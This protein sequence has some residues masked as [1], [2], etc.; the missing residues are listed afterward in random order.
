MDYNTQATFTNNIGNTVS[1]G[2]KTYYDRNLI[3]SAHARLVHAELGQK[4]PIPLGSGKTIEFRRFSPLP[5]AL[6]PLTEGATPRGN[7][8]NIS[9]V[10]AKVEQY[11]DYVTMS[12]LLITTDLDDMILQTESVLGDQAGRTLDTVIREKVNAG[13]N[14]HYGSGHPE[15]ILFG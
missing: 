12:D 2:N 15:G 8:L 10:E 3:K 14:V 7:Q 13:T 6:T 11:G 9:T 5:K 1:A 4:R